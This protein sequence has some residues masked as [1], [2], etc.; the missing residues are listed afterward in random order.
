MASAA[1]MKVKIASAVADAQQAQQALFGAIQKINDAI[2][3][4]VTVS[5]NAVLMEAIS[6][7]RNADQ[8]IT[9]ATNEIT[10]AA[11]RANAYAAPL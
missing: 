6:A 7:L 10:R 11:D 8:E 4:L 9:T 3:V 5:D 1:E 2:S